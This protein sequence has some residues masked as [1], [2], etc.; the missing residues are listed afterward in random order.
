[1]SQEIGRPKKRQQDWGM[2]GQWSSQRTQDIYQL[3]LPS[4]MGAVCGTPKR[5]HSDIKDHWPQITITHIIIMKMLEIWQVSL[6]CGTE[7]QRKHMHW[8]NDCD[9]LA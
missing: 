4:Y 2:A 9:R 1:M 6:K 7:T 8:K 5:I 3:N